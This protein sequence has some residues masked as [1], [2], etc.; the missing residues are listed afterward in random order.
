M[1]QIQKAWLHPRL[2]TI[3][4][5]MGMLCLAL[6]L[7]SVMTVAQYQEIRNPKPPKKST[8]P[9]SMLRQEWLYK[10]RTF[11]NNIIP[12]NAFQNAWEQ[13]QS[14]PIVRP[15]GTG[16]SV[17]SGSDW[18]FW[19]PDGNVWTFDGTN[20]LTAGLSCR[21]NTIAIH[22]TTPSTVYIGVAKAGLWKS[23]DSGATW[24]NLTD[25]LSSQASGC[26]VLDPVNPNI[27]Y[28][29]T[30]ETYNQGNPAVPALNGV[31]IFKS[32]DSGANWTLIGNSTFAGKSINDIAINPGNTSQWVVATNQGIYTTTDGGNT[33]TL[34]QAGK[35]W[36]VRRHATTT[37]ILYAAVGE[38]IGNGTLN[39]IY[40]STDGGNTWTRLTANGLP[41]GT[42]VGRVNLD[43][44]K[45]NSNVVYALFAKPHPTHEL[46]SIWKTTDGGN[47]WADTTNGAN[48]TG[49]QGFYD[50][51]IRV[52]PTDANTAFVGIV[53]L[54]RTTNGGTSWADVNSGQDH[55]AMA[56]DP[57]NSQNIYLGHDPGMVFSSNGGAANS[58]SRRNFGRGAME[59]Y[60]FDI[61]P[62]NPAQLI[63]GAQ[64]NGVFLRTANLTPTPP[65]N[66]Y[67]HLM[68]GDGVSTAYNFTDPDNVVF[69]F[70]FGNIYVSA[71]G[72]FNAVNTAFAGEDGRVSWAPPLVNDHTTPTRFYVGTYRVHRSND[73]GNT[74]GFVSP[75]LTNE[76]SFTYL[77][78]IT[79][80]PS[81]SNVVYTGSLDGSVSVCTTASSLTA[82]DPNT[83]AWTDRTA[84]LTS[85]S[86]GGIAVDPTNPAIVYVGF[87]GYGHPHVYKSI[88][89][90]ATWT[91]ITGNLP[92]TSVNDLLVHP[93]DPTTLFAATDTGVFVTSNGG[94][95]WAR[96][97]NG[98]P[99]SF[100]TKLRANS[101][102]LLVASFGRGI[103][104]VPFTA[105]TNQWYVDKDS[106][107]DTN[108]GTEAAPFKT[109]NRAI[110]AASAGHTIYVKQGNYGTD[111]GRILKGVRLVNWGNAGLSR[112]GQP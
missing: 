42:A 39:G 87:Q 69:S 31:G 55:H 96:Y 15:R 34:R 95:T 92:D 35:A 97:G 83:S 93:S 50:L 14:L 94:T 49:F 105:A 82:D 102:H 63:A 64:D 3:A 20:A 19:G 101:T 22:P 75:D 103:W 43:I 76:S 33:Y 29:G 26:V 1:K 106:G 67:V 8:Q 84:G 47:T 109:V 99:T 48:P 70:P 61:H 86:V 24:T 60:D 13:A 36:T 110:T 72:G 73:N 58:W 27:V 74:W 12:A 65:H 91:N 108:P 44:C 85:A 16:R 6:T 40:K 46:H 21:V 7:S 38:P 54:V 62:T 37:S 98:L 88:N 30:G 32:T 56:F 23:T 18:E 57:T 68:F 2:F 77:N 41:S 100:Y 71:T 89:F 17:F 112:I 59:F 45:A 104:R 52:S 25:N 10:A 51:L 5:R 79:V 53:R 78:V 107:L 111:T 11:P 28:Y 90:G 80:A 66:T 81:S 9:S 4:I